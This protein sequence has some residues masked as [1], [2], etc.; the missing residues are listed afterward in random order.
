[1][2]RRQGDVEQIVEA[3]RDRDGLQAELLQILH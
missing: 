3:H 1:V 2:I